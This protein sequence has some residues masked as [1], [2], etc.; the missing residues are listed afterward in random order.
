MNELSQLVRRNRAGDG[1]ALTS[2][3]SAHE[4]VLLASLLLARDTQY[5]IVIEA[6][7][8]QSNQFGGYTGL[9]PVDFVDRVKHIATVHAVDSSLFQFG[10]DHLGP[11]VW[12][13][14][15][16]Q[17]AMAKAHVMIQAYVEAGFTKIHL[18]CSEGCKGE[19]AQVDDETSAERAV[20][21][22]KT[23][24]AHA[25]DPSILSYIIGT[26]V[27]PP[28][29]A[30]VSDQHDGIAP[31]SSEHARETLRVY[32]KKFANAQLQHAWQRVVGL[33][34]QPGL[35]FGPMDI[36]RFAIESQDKLSAALQDTPHI[37]FEA[38]STDY[39]YDAVYPELA[40]RHFAFLKVGPALTHAYR[41][42]IYALNHVRK[43]CYPNGSCLDLPTLMEQLMRE[44][45]E[46][47][48]N[49]Y[50][51]NSG[52]LQQQLHFSYADR[53]RYYW[54]TEQ[55]TRAVSELLVDLSG[56][57]IADPIIEQ[58]FA[59]EVIARARTLQTDTIDWPKALVLAQVQT[60]L[61]PY[62]F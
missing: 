40:R 56:R 23:C 48:Q 31:T 39:Q 49:H 21:L 12:K 35:E 29:G 8:N 32:E 6:T 36:D 61:L 50:S 43:W 57:Q 44:R 37:G 28:G 55:A 45:P 7:S 59:P 11:Q 2:V 47:W 16:H 20:A 4:D 10:G 52:T 1:C 62:L 42:A 3:C 60:A 9:T 15:P 14:E 22:A 25:P 41:Q 5:P 13:N 17:D 58:Y 27:P 51:D 24:E 38:H 33:V 46:Y 19:P 18:D 54:P 34:V 26:E 53:I 30:R